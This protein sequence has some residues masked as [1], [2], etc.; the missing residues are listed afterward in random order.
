MKHLL[1][2]V[3]NRNLQSRIRE[4][5]PEELIIARNRLCIHCKHF[6]DFCKSNL[7]PITSHNEDC[8]YYKDRI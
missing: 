4:T 2:P 3:D 1:Q 6:D 7:L 5:Y 8:P